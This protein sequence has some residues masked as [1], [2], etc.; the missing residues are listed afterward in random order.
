MP[1]GF[2]HPEALLLSGAVVFLLWAWR[3]S[4]AGL[5]I[6]RSRASLVLR[7]VAVMAVVLA[8]AG[9]AIIRPCRD[10]AVVF[11]LDISDSVGAGQRAKAF[12]YIRGACSELSPE[13]HAGLVAFAREAAI[14]ALPAP[15]RPP[16]A[17]SSIVDATGTDI[18]SGLRL[19]AS[20]FTGETQKRIVL[21][22]DGGQ[23]AGDALTQA[24]TLA[25]D[26]VAI[27]AVPFSRQ[28]AAEVTLE[29]L[30]SPVSLQLGQPFRV[31]AVAS[32]NIETPAQLTLYCNGVPAGV[33]D[34]V[35][36]PGLNRIDFRQCIEEA[37]F[38]TYTAV[39]VPQSD[40]QPLNNRGI[41]FVEV[42]GEMS[43][44]CVQEDNVAAGPLVSKLRKGGLR[45]DICAPKKL[46]GTLPELARYDVVMFHD[47]NVF[48][49]SEESLEVLQKY[50]HDMGGG[51]MMVGG[52]D[53][54]GA[55]GWY[56]TPVE[57]ILPVSLDVRKRAESPNL[58][59][60][61]L[62]DKSGSMQETVVGGLTKLSLA[63][64]AAVRALQLLTPGDVLGVAMVD[65]APQWIIRPTPVGGNRGH[66]ANTVR[67][68]RGGGGGIYVYSGLAAAYGSLEQFKDKVR[69]V[70]L[71]AD[72]SDSE[73]QEGCEDAVKKAAGE[74]ITLTS[75][76]IGKGCDV[77]FL[78]Q[79]SRLGNG[80]FFLTEDA[81]ELPKIFMKDIAVASRRTIVEERF[82]P[83]TV[84]AVDILRGIA[85]K[86][87][88]LD[89]YVATSPRPAAEVIL[90]SHKRDPVLARWHHGLGRS[91]AFTSDA[92]GRWSSD[93]LAWEGYD[94]F[95]KQ[96]VRWTARSRS[97]TPVR[98]THRVADGRIRVMV[99]ALDEKG[100]Y[101]NFC[102][103][104]VHATLP[105]GGSAAAD[106]HQS[107]PGRYMAE[108]PLGEYG[109]YV[110]TVGE[111]TEVGPVPVSTFG[112]S[113]PYSPEHGSAGTN[114]A[115]IRSIAE[116]TGGRVEP[117]QEDVFAP[118]SS[119]ASRSTPLG[120]FLIVLALLLLVVEVAVRRLSVPWTAV[121]KLFAR[122]GSV[123]ESQE[124]LASLKAVKKRADRSL[125]R[126]P[127]E[128]VPVTT[129]RRDDKKSVPEAPLEKEK[130]EKEEP[131]ES[132]LRRLLDVKRKTRRGK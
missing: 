39:I 131:Q 52:P 38:Y 122:S 71:F 7:V 54:F 66:L 127:T 106:F 132:H 59:V 104:A 28:A 1:F 97:S 14:E 61:I 46:P 72:G 96:L 87:P 34:T 112:V 35:L 118:T 51:F 6:L 114:T 121:K 48:G 10:L 18:A 27:D 108:I 43:V 100:E 99:D 64:E 60:V 86:L 44:L 110:L 90:V 45:V 19:A 109:G 20:T 33:Q 65:E 67:A 117:K 81:R 115:L 124:V 21:L 120:G 85:G 53:S 116:A 84:A 76:A 31:S 17:I 113:V 105:G 47:V 15:C 2:Q 74:K 8:L 103:F 24:R 91:V 69:H 107:G 5:T 58:A 79:I 25:S 80:R 83:V 36:K 128:N 119:G 40:T 4:R 37:G 75:V 102:D 3:G 32:A 42:R 11:C 22:T 101:K 94:A 57:R 70:L 130:P 125:T 129:D 126:E 26:G 30:V 68:A 111:K 49:F 50:V 98:V 73:Q 29:R 16:G 82:S 55:G 89:G 13:K 77:P 9:T 92:T 93:W 88:A 63:Q 95:W 23:N 62:I 123:A 41:S 78:M 12:E 56:G